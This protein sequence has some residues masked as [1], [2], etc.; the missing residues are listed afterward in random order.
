MNRYREYVESLNEEELNENMMDTIKKM[1]NSV[2]DAKHK[3]DI[4]NK[5][6]KQFKIDLDKMSPEDK[7]TAQFKELHKMLTDDPRVLYNN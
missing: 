2:K 3:M 7:M 1:F 5:A 6:K 4:K